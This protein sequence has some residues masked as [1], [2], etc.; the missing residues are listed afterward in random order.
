MGEGGLGLCEL[1]NVL[2]KCRSVF[3]RISETLLTNY[4][5]VLHS[6]IYLHYIFK[7]FFLV[8]MASFNKTL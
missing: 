4:G 2:E 8:L 3:G 5:K 7:L 6:V 1:E